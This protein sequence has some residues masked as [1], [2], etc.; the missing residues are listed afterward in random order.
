[1]TR[2]PALWEFLERYHEFLVNSLDLVSFLLIT[3]EAV[4][5]VRPLIRGK[6]G[7]RMLRFSTAIFTTYVTMFAGNTFITYFASEF[8][9]LSYMA[10]FFPFLA[11]VFVGVTFDFWKNKVMSL[12]LRERFSS[13]FSINLLFVGVALFFIARML[14][15]AVASHGTFGIP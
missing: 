8:A 14:A 5:L 10:R 6:S 4:L 3:P 2:N 7:T 11:G 9:F 13:F 1:M 15:F 12:S